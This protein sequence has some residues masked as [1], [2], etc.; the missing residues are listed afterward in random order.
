MSAIIM[1]TELGFVQC[2]SFC[3]GHSSNRK[4]YTHE[5][6]KKNLQA[7]IENTYA[8]R[9]Q[10]FLLFDTVNFFKNIYT[11]FQTEKRLYFHH[12]F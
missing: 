9:S 4:F 12:S 5:L 11:T 6:C 3:D 8:P 10:T 1:L 2:G 7:S